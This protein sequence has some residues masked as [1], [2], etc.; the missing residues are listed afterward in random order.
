MSIQPF[1]FAREKSKTAR[2]VKITN[3]ISLIT[4]VA[5]NIIFIASTNRSALFFVFPLLLLT[6][7]NSLNLEGILSRSNSFQ[8]F[9]LFFKQYLDSGIGDKNSFVYDIDTYKSASRGETFSYK[10]HLEMGR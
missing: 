10:Y 4:V 9:L 3:T 6:I 1:F 2:Y 7:T 8:L 5:A